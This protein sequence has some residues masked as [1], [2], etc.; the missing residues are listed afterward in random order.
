VKRGDSKKKGG[1]AQNESRSSRELRGKMQG[2]G[3]ADANCGKKGGRGKVD[4]EQCSEGLEGRC[5]KADRAK[6][7]DYG[8]EELFRG[9]V[10]ADKGQ[11]HHRV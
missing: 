9:T 8:A 11:K 7:G 1:G 3:L 6:T 4:V 10:K 5:G 2:V